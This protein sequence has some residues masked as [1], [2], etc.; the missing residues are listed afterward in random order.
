LKFSIHIAFHLLF[1]L[2]I[3]KKGLSTLELSKEFG[4]RQK[5]CWSFKQKVQEA[6]QSSGLYK[7]KGEVHIDECWIGGPEDQK[8]GRSHGNKKL[9]II[10][11]EILEK[12]V[13]RAYAQEIKDSSSASFRPFFEKFIDKDASV[14]TDL[15]SGYKPLLKEYPNMKQVLSDSGNGM[16]DLHIHIM[17]LKSWLRGTHHHCNKD[18]LQGYLNEFHFRFNRRNFDEV[19]FNILPKLMVQNTKTTINAES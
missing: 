13:G 4:L 7:L 11:L 9:V 19:V 3:R 16:P 14:I 1:K 18:R 15:W 5:T 17:N 2:S 6:M 10:A 12:G 8:Q